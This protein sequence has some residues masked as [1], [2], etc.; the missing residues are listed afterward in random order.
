MC[1]CVVLRVLRAPESE[2]ANDRTF[3]RSALHSTKC[4]KHVIFSRAITL[5]FIKA[6]RL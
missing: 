6:C 3:L 1:V 2:R 4:L 5:C